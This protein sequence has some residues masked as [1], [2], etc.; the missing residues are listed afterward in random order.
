MPLTEKGSEIMHNLK[1]EYGSKEGESAFYAMK[2]SGKISGVDCEDSAPLP[3]PA[4][5]PPN[6]TSTEPLPV[7]PAAAPSVTPV[8][9]KDS[10]LERLPMTIRQQDTFEHAEKRWN[11]WGANGPN[12]TTPG[13]KLP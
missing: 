5:Y 8:G 4:N 1:Q 9:M 6:A 10:P 13:T 11:V 12:G 3:L 7:A 2:N